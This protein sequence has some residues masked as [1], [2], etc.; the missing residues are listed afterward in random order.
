[1]AFEKLNNNT[2]PITPNNPSSLQ[3]N[4]ET[5]HANYINTNYSVSMQ[6]PSN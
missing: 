6:Y 1:L 3:T 4:S 5:N 2:N